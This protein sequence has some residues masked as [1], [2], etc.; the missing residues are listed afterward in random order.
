MRQL[1]NNVDLYYKY[2]RE[3]NIYTFNSLKNFILCLCI[4]DLKPCKSYNSHFSIN[5]NHTTPGRH[6]NSLVVYGFWQLD[7]DIVNDDKILIAFAEHI[8]SL[9][10]LI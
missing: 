6:E 3:R 9:I 8:F 10:Q 5:H 1:E 4:Y 7:T 2:C